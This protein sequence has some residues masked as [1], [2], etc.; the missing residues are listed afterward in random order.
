MKPATLIRRQLMIFWAAAVLGVVV[1]A[2][3]FLRIP[4]AV[5]YHRHTVHADF[6][7][8]TGLY[9]GAEVVFRGQPIG[10][11]TSMHLERGRVVVDLELV[12]DVTVP[13][14]VYAQIHS[15][16]AVGE[17]YVDLVPTDSGTHQVLAAGDTIPET[18]TS[19]PVEIGPVLDN[20][21]ALV[22]SVDPDHL[23]TVLDETDKALQGRTGDLQTIL[24]Q[25]Q[26]LVE[27]ADNSFEPTQRLITDTDPLL[28]T[29]NQHAPHIRRLS[30]NLNQ[31]TEEL[32]EGDKDL[33][34]LLAT[35][36]DFTEEATALVNDLG[37]TLPP[38]LFPANQITGILRTY[39][40]AVASLLTTYPRAVSIVQSV[41]LPNLSDHQVRLTVGNAE[42]PP[43][44]TTGFV[45]VSQWASP[46]DNAPRDTPLVYCTLPQS[47]PRAVRGARNVP[48]PTDPGIRTGDASNCPD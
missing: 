44:C 11:V 5:G 27:K 30:T 8:T 42:D 39:N 46:F 21:Q 13:A 3:V 28:G 15:R 20:V 34:A 35:G 48:C 6:D 14:D 36:P 22:S 33:R 1:L 31:V 38:L 7:Q 9:T 26:S 10:K 25:G 2:L 45:P 43:E 16:S 18:R 17:Q 47:D 41:T 29:V 12:D 19:T 23:A 32:R 24:D 40:G 4:E 37:Q